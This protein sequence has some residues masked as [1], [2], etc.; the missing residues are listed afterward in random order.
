MK[1]VA[2]G[3]PIR[4][5]QDITVGYVNWKENDI[6]SVMFLTTDLINAIKKKY[7]IVDTEEFHEI[8]EDDTVAM[9]V[10]LNSLIGDGSIKLVQ[11]YHTPIIA[12]EIISNET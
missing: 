1:Q 4:G 2:T 9:D 10:Y 12:A 3:I 6:I 7:L 8:D 5:V 11:T